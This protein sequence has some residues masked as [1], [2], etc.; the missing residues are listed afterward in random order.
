MDFWTRWFDRLGRRGPIVALGLFNSHKPFRMP[1]D[2]NIQLSRH[3]LLH[4]TILL[5]AMRRLGGLYEKPYQKLVSDSI[6]F[7]EFSIRPCVAGMRFWSC[8]CSE[9]NLLF[10]A[11]VAVEWV[12]D[13]LSVE[14]SSPSS[15]L[16]ASS[17]PG[18]VFAFGRS[19]IYSSGFWSYRSTEVPC[20]FGGSVA[21]CRVRAH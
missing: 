17:L 21:G 2:P 5:A 16:L 19:T 1:G 14:G 4:N 20:Y 11:P 12:P 3:G 10:R 13:T 15:S 6:T 8:E 7:P 9:R 18:Y